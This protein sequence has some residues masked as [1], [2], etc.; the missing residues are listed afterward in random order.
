MF[1]KINSVFESESFVEYLSNDFCNK[2]APEFFIKLINLIPKPNNWQRIYIYEKDIEYLNLN[3]RSRCVLN[4]ISSRVDM[5]NNDSNSELIYP[6]VD[7]EILDLAALLK[8]FQFRLYNNRDIVWDFCEDFRKIR[9]SISGHQSFVVDDET[10]NENFQ[11]LKDI[12]NKID[13]VKQIIVRQNEVVE[14]DVNILFDSFKIYLEKVIEDS[15]FLIEKHFV[16][17]TNS[18]VERKQ[19]Y[20][21]NVFVDE[22]TLVSEK[23]LS[24]VR[25]LIESYKKEIYICDKTVEY[26]KDC[27]KNN[28]EYITKAKMA[29]DFLTIGAE[30]RINSRI[31]IVKTIND[32]S[33]DSSEEI[34]ELISKEI[35]NS[36]D[37]L[38]CVITEKKTLA[39]KLAELRGDKKSPIAI[40]VTGSTTAK[41][42]EFNNSS[43]ESNVI[44]NTEST[45]YIS[46]IKQSK[47]VVIEFNEKKFD[48]KSTINS[49]QNKKIRIPQKGDT[50]FV[51]GGIFDSQYLKLGSK[52]SRGGEGSIFEFE[53][54]GSMVIKIYDSAISTLHKEKLKRMVKMSIEKDEDFFSRIC[55]PRSL[56]YDYSGDNLIG[57]VMER[58]EEGVTLEEYL[59]NIQLGELNATRDSLLGI[60][61]NICALFVELHRIFNGSVLMGDVN[62]RN[63]L[64]RSDNEI[65][66]IDVDSYQVEEFVC[67]VGTP[68]FTSARLYNLFEKT[69]ENYTSI[70][71]TREDENFAIA[72]LMFYIIFIKEYPFNT[73]DAFSLKDS[74]C[75]RYYTYSR[76]NSQDARRNK[77]Y[78]NLNYDMKEAFYSVFKNG[79][80]T[81]SDEMLWLS[82]LKQQREDIV[83]ERS[84]NLIYPT[85]YL[86]DDSDSFEIRKCRYCKNEFEA[87]KSDQKADDYNCP[88]CIAKR[89]IARSKMCEAKCCKCGEFFV[90]NEWDAAINYSGER[91]II[92][93]DCSDDLK[94]SKGSELDRDDPDFEKNLLRQLSFAFKNYEESKI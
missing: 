19:L 44:V 14:Y 36:K 48:S 60:C 62:P 55:W 51:D 41:L 1:D 68:D 65:T 87:A 52:I 20:F 73:E 69:G 37:R 10:I 76:E 3:Q 17:F 40:R 67:P 24:Y 86:K 49:T 77:I 81:E 50:I 82:C 66:F 28:S 59:T 47:D 26:L 27:V 45:E 31:N 9:N 43:T 70:K 2:V 33:I 21:Y 88:I 74:I 92:C 56:V 22:T 79:L 57:Y 29:L 94:L 54:Y 63:I 90:F 4:D 42:F 71:R 91:E 13:N 15:N 83:N 64:V 11:K 7:L 5:L 8:L 23:G 35:I 75:K 16:E 78:K 58:V 72:V 6:N 32:N 80:L 84:S 53:G 30:G 61:L 18:I 46:L 89:S 85:S 93:P 34:L 25:S 38:F 39:K 12:F